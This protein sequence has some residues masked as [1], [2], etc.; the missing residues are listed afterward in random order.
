[1]KD[2]ITIGIGLTLGFI[3]YKVVSK[4]NNENKSNFSSACG[5]EG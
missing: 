1:M 5:C 3:V 4:N 2:L